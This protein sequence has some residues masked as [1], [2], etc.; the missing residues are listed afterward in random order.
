[1]PLEGA[2]VLIEGTGKGVVTNSD[3]RFEWDTLEPGTYEITTS[4]I[5]YFPLRKKVILVP[6]E[7]QKIVFELKPNDRLDEVVISGNL[8]PMRKLESTI[9]VEVYS[10]AFLKQNPSAGVFDALENVNGVRP[11]INCSV[12]NTGDIHIN[13][14]DGPYTAILIDGMPIV[15]SLASMYG[16]SG[17]PNGMIEK[18]EIV[19]GPSGTLYGSEAMGGLINVITKL[20]EYSPQIFMDMY[21]TSWFENNLDAGITT[22]IADSVTFLSGTNVF[23]YDQKIDHNEDNFTDAAIQKR[24]SVF[25]K[26]DWNRKNNAVSSLMVRFQYEDRWGGALQ[27]RPEFRG[28]TEV[29]GES[30]YTRR[31]EIIGSHAFDAE[32]N[33]ELQWSYADHDQNSMYGDTPYLGRQKTGFTQLLWRKENKAFNWLRGLSFRYLWYDDN[34]DATASVAN[35]NMPDERY[36]PGIFLENEVSLTAKQKLLLGFRWDYHQLHGHIFTPRVGYKINF[37]PQTLLRLNYGTGF[38]IVNIF[39][40]DHAAF[41]GGGRELL[42]EDT[43]NPERSHSFNLN[44]YKKMY[45]QKGWIMSLDAAAWHTHFS[46]QIL[47]DYDTDANKILY[48][49]LSGHAIS[50]GF[51]LNFN[52][53]RSDF[54]INAGV[55]FLDNY[56][57]EEGV[58]TT[59]VLTENWS[60]SWGITYPVPSWDLTF[61]YT[62]SIYGPMRLPLLGDADPRPSYSPVWSL[63][64]IKINYSTSNTTAFFVGIKNLLNWTPA[65]D[66]PFLIAGSEAPFSDAFDPTY[67]YAPNQGIRFFI[68][69]NYTLNP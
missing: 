26:L 69:L 52:A 17:I 2:T 7:T 15:S 67:I 18:V 12:C 43:I 28:S 40:E 55:S 36:V 56:V 51:S 65:D 21:S 39:T 9:P 63:Q 42:I 30:I 16:L 22:P 24:F 68:G 5:G 46:N 27:W 50:Q 19:K 66:I 47:P 31:L 48:G 14:M 8:K 25:E 11:Q 29:Y 20:P 13:G 23:W 6:N 34:T 38:R 37:N 1:M 32:K 33:V 35:L 41:V 59:P 64:N 57:E 4:H 3:G 49:N 60:G 61:N 53:S 10:A 58:R 54:I 62:G 45:T 44:F